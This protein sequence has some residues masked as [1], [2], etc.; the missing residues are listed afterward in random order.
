VAEELIDQTL[1]HYRLDTLLGRGSTGAVFKAQDLQGQR[2]V[3]LKVLDPRLTQLPGFG[4]QFEEYIQAV[5]QLHHPGIIEVLDWGQ[6]RALSYVVTPLLTDDTLLQML[7]ELRLAKRWISLKDAIP[8]VRQLSLVV[9]YANQHEVVGQDFRPNNIMFKEIPGADLPY[10]VVLTAPGGNSFY[11]ATAP[12]H[13]APATLAYLPPEQILDQVTGVHTDVYALGVLLYILVTKE[14]PVQFKTLDEAVSFHQRQ[15]PP[16]PNTI[17]PD[18]PGAIVEI[19]TKATAK[20]PTDRFPD[21]ATL[22]EALAESMG[23]VG[24]SQIEPPIDTRDTVSEK[25]SFPGEASEEA[26]TDPVEILVEPTQFLATPGHI[27]TATVGILNRGD[28]SDLFRVSVEGVHPNWILDIPHLIELMPGHQQ[29]IKL[30]IKPPLSPQTR[31]GRYR[32]T[33]KVVGRKKPSLITE[34]TR[35]LTVSAYSQFKAALQPDTLKAGQWGQIIVENQGNTPQGYTAIFLSEDNE[36]TFNPPEVHLRVNEGQSAIAQF[37]VDV[38]RPRLLGTRQ[39]HNYAIQIRS[40]NGGSQN[41]KGVVVSTGLVP[42]WLLTTLLFLC[43]IASVVGAFAYNV[44]QLRIGA[45][46]TTALV[47]IEAPKATQTAQAVEQQ[48]TIEAATATVVYLNQ[49]DDR[50][51]LTNGEEIDRDTLPN[52]RDTDEDGLDDGDEIARGTDPLRPDTDS[53]GLKDG[54]EVS[55]GLDPLNPDTDGDGTPDAADPDPGRLPTVTPGPTATPTPMNIPPVISISEPAP[56]STYSAPAEISLVAVPS[57]TDG[58]VAKVE[59]F[60]G[61]VLIGLVD[62]SPFRLIWRDVQAGNYRITAIAT[63]NSGATS[64]SANIDIIV[65]QPANIPPTISITEPLVGATFDAGGNILIAAIAEDTDGRVIEVQFYANTTL[66][67]IITSRRTRYEYVWRN[68]TPGNYTLSAVAVDED[69]GTTV[70]VPV[71]ITVNE[72]AN[73]PPTINLIDPKNGETFTNRTPIGLTAIAN[74]IDGTVIQVDFFANGVPIGTS[75]TS[76]YTITWTGSITGN[77]VLTADATDDDGEKRT[78]SAVTITITV[79]PRDARRSSAIYD[80]PRRVASL[81]MQS[82]SIIHPK[83]KKAPQ[84][85]TNG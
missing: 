24:S 25:K 16:S 15:V 81:N 31:A 58:T 23:Q 63:D 29:T 77:Y 48:A 67:D 5:A 39:M 41:R 38:Q 21:V 71:N 82:F 11:F 6:A 66:L 73:V 13:L 70:A 1:D 62:R 57:D 54:D 69:G 76:P 45:A 40:G 47:L 61:P 35:T 18:L 65:S 78:S 8:L 12:E 7:R 50:D 60:A 46:T 2:D 20:D 37:Q 26:S 84:D 34:V 80:T 30:A 10:Q 64:T 79:P 49:D 55:R 32:L 85:S 3:V 28:Q 53:D 43:L 83:K 51:G 22:A 59:F 44:Q 52:K 4:A 56:G 19:I 9:H 75:L 68:V 72:P 33:I 42:V 17:R 27:T 74:D 36:L 14:T